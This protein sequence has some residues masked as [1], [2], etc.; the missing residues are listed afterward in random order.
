MRFDLWMGM[1]DVPGPNFQCILRRPN[2][3]CHIFQSQWCRRLSWCIWKDQGNERYSM[4]L[5]G[6]LEA[7][8]SPA[9]IFDRL[10]NWDLEG[11][12]CLHSHLPVDLRD[13]S[14]PSC[15]QQLLI[16]HFCVLKTSSMIGI[17]YA[18]VGFYRSKLIKKESDIY[19]FWCL[20]WYF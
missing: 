17:R 20:D 13:T 10:G 7:S 19:Y 3:H 11:R 5:G 12:G 14:P 6:S 15:T 2:Q 8:S 16:D 9:L 4:V 1:Q 18:S